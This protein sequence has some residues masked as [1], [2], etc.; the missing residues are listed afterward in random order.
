MQSDDNEISFAF[1]RLSLDPEQNDKKNENL[2]LQKRFSK[3][4]IS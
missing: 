4:V 2:H 3:P 1:E